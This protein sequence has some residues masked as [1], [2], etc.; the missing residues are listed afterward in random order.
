MVRFAAKC[1][2]KM[3]KLVRSLE[4]KLG[5]GTSNLSLRIGLHTGAVT[6][7][8]LRY[9]CSVDQVIIVP[10]SHSLYRGRK[11]RFQLFGDSVNTAARME[12]KGVPNKIHIS[13]A[14]ANALEAEG[15]GS[16]VVKRNE[17]IDVKGKGKMQT[18]FAEPAIGTSSFDEDFEDPFQLHLPIAPDDGPQV[19]PDNVSTFSI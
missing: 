5:T 6:A 17:E 12:A 9:V 16:W 19:Y 15:K 14:T 2:A 1:S 11:S 3:K 4:G 18:Y 8:V 7:G 10:V 13:Q